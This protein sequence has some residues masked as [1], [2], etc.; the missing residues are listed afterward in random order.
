MEKSSQSKSSYKFKT[1]DRK[2][3]EKA[4]QSSSA[5]YTISHASIRNAK[6]KYK[7][8]AIVFGVLQYVKFSS[9]A[10]KKRL[11]RRRIIDT[12]IKDVLKRRGKQ[13]ED[14]TK[15]IKK[16]KLKKCI[17]RYR[18]N[19]RQQE[20]QTSELGDVV[21]QLTTL[22]IS[23][24]ELEI[25]AKET[26]HSRRFRE[27]CENCT[28]TQLIQLTD[29]L[30]RELNHFQRRAH[31]VKKIRAEAHRRFVIGFREVQN[32]LRI[33]KIKLVLIATDC[34]PCEGEDGLDQTVASIKA[35]C[36][37]QQVPVAFIL[38]RR[39]MA[40]ALY[41][42]ASISC[43]G[44]INYDGSQ[45]LFGQLLAS[46]EEAQNAYQRL[47]QHTMEGMQKTEQNQ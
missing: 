5:A 16:S 3:Y 35:L 12:A 20:R 47:V 21:Q 2:T 27:Y 26:I 41:K 45:T 36:K 37:D 34:D 24:K 6:Y 28:T 46:L 22:T 38:Q 15:R 11:K 19:K 18:E 13:R 7:S 43:V 9:A 25:R 1:I 17:L 39:Q 4:Q 31:A 23:V 14:G 33:K 32:F 42:N 44:I 8:A 30:L 29:Q 40:Y 10:K